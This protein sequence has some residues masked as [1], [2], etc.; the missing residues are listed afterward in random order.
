MGNNNSNIRKRPSKN[1]KLISTPNTS[2][3]SS[4]LSPVGRISRISNELLRRKFSQIEN[5]SLRASFDNLSTINERGIAHI[6]KG[7]FIGY[8]GF[9]DDIGTGPLIYRSF[10]YLANYPSVGHTNT[11]LTYDGLIKAIAIY[12]DLIEGV[13]NEDRTKLLFDSFSISDNDIE[14]EQ[15]DRLELIKPSISQIPQIITPEDAEFLKVIGFYEPDPSKV[16]KVRTQD[17]IKILT[18]LIWLMSSE[19]TSINTNSE[20]LIQNLKKIISPQ[21]I[22][23]IHDDVVHVIDIMKQYDN[24]KSDQVITWLTFQ[25][26]INRNAPNIFRGFIPFMYGQFLIGLTLSQQRKDSLF[27]GP[28]VQYWPKLDSNSDILN[29]MNMGLLSWMLPEKIIKRHHWNCLYS[30][31]KHGFSMNRFYRNVFKYPGPT[32]LLIHADSATSPK[33]DGSGFLFT[34]KSKKYEHTFLLGAYVA[35]PWKSTSNP[36]TC[37]GSEECVLFEIL[38]AFEKFPASKLNSNYVY[39][40]PSFGIGFG[41]IAT[42]GITSNMITTSDQNS[43]VLQIDNTLQFGRYRNDAL[44]DV[45][46]TYRLSAI[47]N[48]FDIPFE[49]VEIEVFGLGGDLAKEKQEKEWEWEEVEAAKRSGGYKRNSNNED[50]ELLKLAGIIDEDSR[51]EIQFWRS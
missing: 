8:L 1:S 46:P 22:N 20:D 5:Y 35:D 15:K 16:S 39:Y 14:N 23:Q 34:S 27:Q 28:K 26:F 47:R 7:A 33:P 12:C 48:F 11:L 18:G 45:K 4:H 49:V 43:F 44:N 41:G 37:F 2:N 36:K 30:S 50:K 25:N 42:S 40:N 24:I 31:S 10:T 3:I 29:Q 9:P 17:M 51:N 6:N 32:L 21:F 38:P 19:M 13:I